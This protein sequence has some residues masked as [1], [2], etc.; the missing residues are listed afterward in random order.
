MADEKKVSFLGTT[1]E[2]KKAPKSFSRSVSD[3]SP[4][5]A[6]RYERYA[7]TGK[8]AREGLAASIGQGLNFAAETYAGFQATKAQDRKST[9]LNSS[10]VSISY[11]VFCL[12]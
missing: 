2:Q 12:K 1:A 7:D 10:H 5:S 11:A 9:R 6:G 8:E 3:V 4:S